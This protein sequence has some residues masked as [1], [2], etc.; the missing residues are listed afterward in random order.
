MRLDGYLGNFARR[1]VE[2]AFNE[3]TRSYWVRRAEAFEAVGNARGD[4]IALACRRHATI[5]EFSDF[6]VLY[7]AIVAERE[8]AHLGAA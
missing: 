4:A 5:C 1:V 8:A 3:A 2:D 7:E 6:D